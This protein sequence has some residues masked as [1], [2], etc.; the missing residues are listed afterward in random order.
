MPTTLLGQHSEAMR[1]NFLR[2][3]GS[4]CWPRCAIHPSARKNKKGKEE[5]EEKD[6]EEL[7]KTKCSSGRPVVS[8]RI[9]GHGRVQIALPYFVFFFFSSFFPEDSLESLRSETCLHLFKVVSTRN[10]SRDGRLRVCADTTHTTLF[11]SDAKGSFCTWN[12]ELTR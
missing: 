4:E 7:K 6:E 8:G 11:V 2:C 1:E 5:E 10:I 12:V 3:G 9:R